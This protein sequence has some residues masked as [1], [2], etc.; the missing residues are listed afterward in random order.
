MKSKD[1]SSVET[2]AV[3]DDH[4]V[5]GLAVETLLSTRDDLEFAG[6]SASVP[7]LLRT[8]DVADLVLLDLNLRDGSKIG[9][10]HV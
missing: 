2:V 1:E 5:V 3:V 10:A 8:S 9:R 6:Y 7:Q 4:E